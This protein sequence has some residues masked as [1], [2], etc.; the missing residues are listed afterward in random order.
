MYSLI[1]YSDTNLMKYRSNWIAFNVPLSGLSSVAAYCSSEQPANS[2]DFNSE[3]NSRTLP[4]FSY[5][6][7]SI[8]TFYGATFS[9]K[10]RVSIGLTVGV[11]DLSEFLV[12]FC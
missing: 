4:S 6:D 12:F 2:A 1:S 7:R 8:T 10:F 5:V 9:N 3:R 11:V